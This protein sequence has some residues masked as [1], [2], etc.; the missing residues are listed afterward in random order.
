MLWPIKKSFTLINR[1]LAIGT[2]YWQ[3]QD[4]TGLSFHNPMCNSLLSVLI[5]LKLNLVFFHFN[6]TILLFFYYHVLFILIWITSRSTG[7][8]LYLQLCLRF[9]LL[10]FLLCQ[11]LLRSEPNPNWV[12]SVPDINVSNVIYSQSFTLCKKINHRINLGR[13]IS[14]TFT[15]PWGP[16][17]DSGRMT[18]GFISLQLEE[19]LRLSAHFPFLSAESIPGYLICR[20]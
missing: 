3:I 18:Y 19:T 5:H 10:Y 12:S 15:G 17:R 11:D 14:E 6:L 8:F 7:T 20:F 2:N 16:S 13:G 9:M 4:P 1:L